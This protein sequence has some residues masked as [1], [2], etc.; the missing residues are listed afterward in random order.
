M[1]MC[2]SYLPE[3]EGTITFKYNKSKCCLPTVACLTVAYGLVCRHQNPVFHGFI[4]P[5]SRFLDKV[6][7]GI[8]STRYL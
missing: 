3:T 4:F 8:V 2:K 6:L 7:H 5:P 1:L